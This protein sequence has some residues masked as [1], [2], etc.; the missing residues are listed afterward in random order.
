MNWSISKL[1]KWLS[2]IIRCV[3]IP[4]E[5]EQ[6]DGILPLLSEFPCNQPIVRS[7]SK[8]IPFQ[9]IINKDV[10]SNRP[11]I[12]PAH[13]THPSI[14]IHLSTHPSIHPSIHLFNR[15]QSSWTADPSNVC[16]CWYCFQWRSPLGNGISAANALSEGDRGF[17]EDKPKF[18][19][20]IS[21]CMPV[22][23]SLDISRHKL[24]LDYIH[25]VTTT[26]AE[27]WKNFQITTH[28]P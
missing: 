5:L 23:Y 6:V 26:K 19:R 18:S 10:L 13:P 11:Y 22:V 15:I 20:G 14:P 9:L 4:C 12:Y 21:L 7:I 25:R 28:T 8:S 1:P 3:I 27:I 2:H 24:T 17:F 16:L